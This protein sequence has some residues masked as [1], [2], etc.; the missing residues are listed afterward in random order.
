M[1]CVMKIMSER[2]RLVQRLLASVDDTPLENV[3][4]Y[5]IHKLAYSLKFIKACGLDGI[6]N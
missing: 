6:P 2:W 5:H 4:S 3:K 1:T